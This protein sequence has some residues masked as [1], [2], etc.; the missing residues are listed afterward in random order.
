M[1]AAAGSRMEAVG[2]T[3][4]IR[5]GSTRIP[6]PSGYTAANG[7]VAHSTVISLARRDSGTARW[8]RSRPA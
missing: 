3:T 4:P 1:R 6:T 5:N 7:A 8:S 2:D